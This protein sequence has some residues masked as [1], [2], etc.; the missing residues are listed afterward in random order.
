MTHDEIKIGERV[1]IYISTRSLEFRR[2][3]AYRV[4]LPEFGEFYVHRA[5]GNDEFGHPLTGWSL[6]EAETLVCAA[7]NI[8]ETKEEAV[9]RG[10]TFLQGKGV[11]LFR[12]RVAYY[13][14]FWEEYKSREVRSEPGHHHTRRG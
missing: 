6:T 12:E 14:K 10:L 3:Y 2:V 5:I 4:T 9:V 7:E 8:A 13:K 11:P 1:V